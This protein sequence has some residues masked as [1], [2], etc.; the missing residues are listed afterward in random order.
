[1]SHLHICSVR[2]YVLRCHTAQCRGQDTSVF[3]GYRWT[4]W[5][6][7]RPRNPRIWRMRTATKRSCLGQCCRW[8]SSQTGCRGRRPLR[9]QPLLLYSHAVHRG[10]HSVRGLPP[11][12]RPGSIRPGLRVY[13]HLEWLLTSLRQQ[14]CFRVLTSSDSAL[15]STPCNT[16][17]RQLLTNVPA[18]NCYNSM[19]LQRAMTLVRKR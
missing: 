6:R 3:V 18:C 13:S 15:C 7:Q 12:P 2:S 9:L 10:R 19:L 11:K 17:S 14:T 8:R 1:M 4:T 16:L 5:A